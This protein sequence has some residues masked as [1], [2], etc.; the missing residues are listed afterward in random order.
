VTHESLDE[1][2]ALRVRPRRLL[3]AG[4]PIVAA[5]AALAMSSPA[6][7]A[8]SPIKCG[9]VITQNTTLTSDIGPCSG[10]G[11]VVAASAV[12]LNLGGYTV[13]GR[14]GSAETSGVLMDHVTG[15]TVRNGT[16]T[17]FDAG[18][19]VDGGSGNT[20]TA[21]TAHDNINDNTG[22]QSKTHGCELGDGITTNSSDANTITANSAVHNGPY[23]GISLLED[24]DNNT[25]SNN[26]VL[27]NNVPN[28]TK[29]GGL[30]NCGA[31][32]SRPIQDIGIRIEGPGADNNVVRSN[33]VVNSAIGGITIHGYVFCPPLPGGG[34]GPSQ[35][36]NT[37]NLIQLN[38]VADTGK[39]TYVQDSL[40]DGIGVLRQ[41]PGNVVGVSQGNTI[42]N[43]TVVRS[44][45]DGIFLGNP[46]QPGTTAG[47]VVVG[48]TITDSLFDGIRV[49]RG[50]VNN[51][52][53][54]NTATSSGDVDGRD[55]NSACDNNLWTNN[56]FNYVNQACVSATA[57]IK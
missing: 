36:Q 48:N 50:S 51:T 8:G 52:I 54:S 5:G 1:R 27:D 33:R 28:F 47:S 19:N 13:T 3:I 10:N 25:V 21:I 39:D 55:D 23:S 11:L 31:P 56:L 40:A 44:F 7:S 15:S 16:V 35:D 45:H 42:A 41:G 12:T 43:N 32:F 53:D 30:G 4:L 17:G 14:N 38:Y 9:S 49:P 22:S 29:G 46:T 18:V 6:A 57:V 20:V 37:A 34:C 24:S 26:T 2:R